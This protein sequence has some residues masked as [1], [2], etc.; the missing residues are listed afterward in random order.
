MLMMDYKKMK[1][2]SYDDESLGV[3]SPCAKETQY[4]EE[5]SDDAQR[6]PDDGILGKEEV[7]DA[8]HEKDQRQHEER[9][10]IRRLHEV[11]TPATHSL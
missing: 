6:V 9:L 11:Q 10:L 8:K 1:E 4:S 3:L 2:S 7:E 5:A